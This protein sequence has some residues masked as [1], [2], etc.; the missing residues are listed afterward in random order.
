MFLTVYN[1]S[2]YFIGWSLSLKCFHVSVY[3]SVPVVCVFARAFV[4]LRFAFVRVQRSLLS[5]S[6]SHTLVLSFFH[7]IYMDQMRIYCLSLPLWPNP[8]THSI[9]LVLIRIQYFTG[10]RLSEVEAL[11]KK[12]VSSLTTALCCVETAVMEKQQHNWRVWSCWWLIW[13]RRGLVSVG[14]ESV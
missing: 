8:V 11:F 10:I 5:Y 1:E 13:G 12:A 9:L 14:P 3:L 4:L 7:L 6:A 2:R